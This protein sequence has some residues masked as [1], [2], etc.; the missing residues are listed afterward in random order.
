MG[1]VHS[2]TA[3]ISPYVINS[4]N[5]TNFQIIK[6]PPCAILIH[7]AKEEPCLRERERERHKGT[8]EHSYRTWHTV[9]RGPKEEFDVGAFSH[10]LHCSFLLCS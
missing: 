7:S 5:A 8:R 2:Q 3:P 4:Q 10:L 6:D 9:M 1:Y